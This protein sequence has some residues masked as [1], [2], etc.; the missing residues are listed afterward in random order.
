MVGQGEPPTEKTVEEIARETEEAL[1]CAARLEQE[2]TR[3]RHNGQ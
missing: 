2:A 1:A 3:K